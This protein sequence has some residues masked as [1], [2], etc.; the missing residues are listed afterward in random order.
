M[1]H[2]HTSDIFHH[3]QTIRQQIQG[4]L[5]NDETTC[6]LYSTDASAYQEMPMAVVRP[7]CVDDI[8]VVVKYAWEHRLPLIPRAAGTSLAGQVVGNGIVVDISRH[9]NKIISVNKEECWVDVEPGVVLDELNL[10]LKPHGLFFGPETSTSNR[11]NLGGMVGNNSCGSHSLVYGSTRDHLLEVSG[12]LSNGNEVTFKALTHDELSAKCSLQS[13]EGDIYRQMMDL[14][15]DDI[16]RQ[17]VKNEF[18][19]PDIKRRNMGYAIDLM[20]NN[21]PF[22]PNGLPFNLCRLIAGS[23]GT[24]MFV[25]RIRLHLVPL[26]PANTGLLCVHLT[27]LTQ[28]WQANLTALKYKPVAIELM[29]KKVLDLT[30]GN[31]VQRKNRFFV[32][33]DP[34]AL[35]L[36]EFAEEDAAMIQTKAQ[37]LMADLKQQGMGY[38]FP[39]LFG[40]DIKKVWNLR[41]SGLGVLSNMPGNDLPVPVIE[42]TAVR[43]EDLADYMTDIAAMLTRYNNDCIYYAHIGTGELHLR[44]VLNMKTPEGLRLFRAIATDTARIVKKYRG[45][46]SGEHGDGRLRGEFIPLMVGQHNYQL[47]KTVKQSFDPR[48]ILNPGKIVDTP[49]MDHFLRYKP[50]AEPPFKPQ[51]RWEQTGGMVQGAE[52]C[53]GS[54]DCRKSSVIGGAMCPSFMA[55]RNERDTTRARANMLREYLTCN[56]S[57]NH[58]LLD[59]V[60][61]ILDLCLMCKACKAECPS[62]I[63]VTKLKAEFLNHYRQQR[64]ATLR[65]Y[66][67]A[68]QPV[69]FRRL[70]PFRKLYNSMAGSRLLRRMINRCLCLSPNLTLP[71]MASTT[72][73]EWHQHRQSKAS[74]PKVYLLADEFIN[75]SDAETGIITIRLLEALGYCVIIPHI[76]N[77]GRTY[78]S[79]GYLSKARK[80]AND[81]VARMDAL[82][83][84]DV[85]LVGIE[86]SSV[87]TF[88]DEYPELVDE[89]LR[90]AAN[91]VAANSLTIEEFLWR[92]MEAGRIT[93]QQF[94]AKAQQIVSHAHCHQKTLSDSDITSKIL[95]FPANYKATE[96]KS[97]CCGMA[98]AFGY[99]AEH[100][101]LAREVG[102]LKLFPAIRQADNDT[103]VAA[104]GFSCRHHIAQ[105]TG[106]KAVHP[107]VVLWEALADR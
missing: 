15:G 73:T 20:M 96:I 41:K 10:H 78:L 59:Q 76:E 74:G 67:F 100:A 34:Q 75:L 60:K 83:S 9:L 21:Q 7:A 97:G 88:R 101:A 107:V 6:L 54:A 26:P 72:M 30:R 11:C 45:S 52:K 103:V 92:E 42:D 14:L 24:L 79:K 93:Q 71:L 99:E 37:Q 46:L 57:N 55:T 81:N 62:N 90:G 17:T 82:L 5:Y 28:A 84:A 25:T 43:V 86:P 85:P 48:G 61:E 105:N 22:N 36:V 4:E 23:E 19:H 87:L 1:T 89:S 68:H 16:N 58:H 70:L 51:F 66:L 94:T 98:G 3:L 77:S 40:N 104:S 80:L 64:G 35:L 53:T 32:Q 56:K 31:I 102:E 18:P 27:E 91:R 8:Q 106:C 33:G 49:T 44:P 47:F 50:H 2:V 69:L 13:L 29:D 63:D 95:S 39:L 38:A 65:D 12:F